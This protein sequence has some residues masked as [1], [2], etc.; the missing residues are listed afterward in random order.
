M[1]LV[2]ILKCV[3]VCLLLAVAYLA[4]IYLISPLFA[5]RRYRKYENVY[6]NEKFI[7]VV[8]EGAMYRED[9]KNGK[10][11]YY[12]QIEFA[13]KMKGLDLKL[14]VFADR[15]S[16]YLLSNQALQEFQNLS[17]EFIDRSDF[18]RGP[19][20]KVFAGSFG[21]DRSN[22][23]WKK[24]RDIF[25]KEIGIN[26]SSRFIPLM[27]E[28]TAERAKIWKSGQNYEMLSE[29]ADITF[30]II[31]KILFGESVIQK[32]DKGRYKDLKTGEVTYL[33]F[34]EMYTKVSNDSNSIRYTM[35]SFIFP[36]LRRHDISHPYNV[37]K[38][39]INEL[40]RIIGD[41]LIT[42]KDEDSV[43]ARV[44]KT[45]EISQKHAIQDIIGFLFAGHETSSHSI[46]TIKLIL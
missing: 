13:N 44:M 7:P 8:G 36:C 16:F 17:P 9:L 24:R 26:F 30:T 41:Y 37:I 4:Y 35:K 28:A 2:L 6:I 14:A 38:R 46:S 39:N 18:S 29:M 27:I 23:M 42:S 1:E 11:S 45:G 40:W 22:E 32:I 19:L 3:A 43:Y 21:H 20:G 33:P 5:I 25:M 15:I 12:H 34:N 31:S 10:A